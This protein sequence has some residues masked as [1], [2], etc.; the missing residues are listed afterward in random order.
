MQPYA[1][2]PG[3]TPKVEAKMRM[4]VQD[5]RS[6][7]TGSQKR[8]DSASNHIKAVHRKLGSQV[9][10]A[11]MLAGDQ[12]LPFNFPSVPGQETPLKAGLA[13]P[14]DLMNSTRG[15]AFKKKE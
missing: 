12:S 10:D 14:A 4:K 7:R 1:D 5:V 9:P 3:Q 6:R 13:K 8:G 15:S 2:D 11:A